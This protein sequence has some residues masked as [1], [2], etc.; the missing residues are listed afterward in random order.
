MLST[1]NPKVGNRLPAEL[2]K[3]VAEF[4]EGDRM[5]RQMPGKKDCVS[6]EIEG[7]KKNIQKRMILR[8]VYEAYLS[9]KEE[10]SHSKLGFSKFAELRPKYVMLPS[11]SGTCLLYTSPSPRD[12]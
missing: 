12:S 5:S 7:E 11:S 4:Y 3:V 1:P 6:V 9:F 8:T 10:H 2:R